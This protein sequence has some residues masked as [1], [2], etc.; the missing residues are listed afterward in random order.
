MR[1]ARACWA[2]LRKAKLWG[3]H[4]LGSCA[5]RRWRSSK[6]ESADFEDIVERVVLAFESRLEL[7]VPGACGTPFDGVVDA[8]VVEN[9]QADVAPF[10]NEVL[11]A[12]GELA[13]EASSSEVVLREAELAP[14]PGR[15]AVE[16]RLLAF[17]GAFGD[18]LG[19]ELFGGDRRGRFGRAL[20]ELFARGEGTVRWQDGFRMVV[21]VGIV[22]DDGG[23]AGG[24]F[25]LAELDQMGFVLGKSLEGGRVG[26][27]Q[28]DAGFLGLERVEGV[29]KPYAV[30]VVLS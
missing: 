20:V 2:A 22:A 19:V 23:V 11:F 3:I 17:G 10:G 7:L 8:L 21:L 15:D 14:V 24:G 28:G 30:H 18:A 9:H 16:G 13:G 5:I 29:W 26:V 6:C 27:E 1:R 12:V 25:H 4:S